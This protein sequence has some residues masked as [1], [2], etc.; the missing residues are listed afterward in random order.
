MQIDIHGRRLF[1][2]KEFDTKNGMHRSETGIYRLKP[3]SNTLVVD[4][5]VFD[6]KSKRSIALSKNDFAEYIKKGTTPFD[7][8]DFSEFK[9]IFKIIHKLYAEYIT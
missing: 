3:N 2:R 8:V 4:S 9:N 6:I 5:D 7:N 1:L